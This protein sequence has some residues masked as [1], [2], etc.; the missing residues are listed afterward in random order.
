M[1]RIKKL[2]LM[3]D[4]VC[5]WWLAYTFDNPFRRVIHKPEKILN[6]YVQVGMTAIDIGCGMGFFSIGMAKLVG[7]KGLV[8]SVD[9]QQKML[10][11]LRKRA[12]RAGL[13]HRIRL[14]R[15]E[16]GNIGVGEKGDFVLT[17]WMVHEV[18]NV[19]EFLGQIYLV[20]KSTGK[21]LLAEPKLH[22]PL[23][24]FER[25]IDCCGQ[26][27]FRMVNRPRILLSRTALFGK[28]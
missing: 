3:G 1:N 25:I 23:S 2:V 6:P 4:H 26:V 9:L 10:D 7:E 11:V 20:L 18:P 21:F 27:G 14:H 24:Q 15:C 16:P 5:P 22:V 12:K 8:I 13:A 28:S 19:E 17:F